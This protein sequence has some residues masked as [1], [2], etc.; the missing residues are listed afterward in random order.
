MATVPSTSAKAS[1][2]TALRVPPEE[3]FWKRYSP[4]GQ[5]PLSLAGS[6]A[7]HALAVGGM[8]LAGLYLASLFDAPARSLPVEPVRMVIEGGGGGSKTGV[9]GGPGIGHGTEDVG[10]PKEGVAAPSIPGLDDAPRPVLNQVEK[11]QV[12]EKFD[13]LSARYIED[14]KSE[15]A[16]AFAQLD[17]KVRQKLADGL[18][19]GKGEGGPGS[20]GGKG[21]GVGTGE[22]PGRGPGKAT[23]TKRERRMLRWHMGFNATNGPEYLA[24]LRGLG[25]ILAIPVSEDP[26]PVFKVVRDLRPGGKLL[27]EELSKIQRIYWIDNNPTSVRDIL[28][29]LGVHL[30]HQPSRFV[31]F[32]PVALETELFQMERR[33]V[34]N[35]LRQPFNEDRIDETRF[36]VVM[37]PRGYRPEL[38]S[39]SMR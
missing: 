2:D 39:V 21:S 12:Q 34:E 33:Y 16:R 35:V 15:M 25:A 37:T 28:A 4:H 11:R 23:L 19:P 36:R 14:S 1:G 29:A 17:D 32:M 3:Q 5:A 26:E 18:R 24:Q 13:P 6:F 27:D 20:G 8:I 31:A 7:L 38:L 10:Q 9:G 30:P 22:G